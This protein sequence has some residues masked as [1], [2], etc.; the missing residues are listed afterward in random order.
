MLKFLFK[1]LILNE[2][3]RRFVTQFIFGMHIDTE[4]KQ[5]QFSKTKLDN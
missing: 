2:F 5:Y 4:A 3:W 1:E